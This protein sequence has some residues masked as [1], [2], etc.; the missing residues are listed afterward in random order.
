MTATY[1]FT[2]INKLRI[3]L[4]HPFTSKNWGKAKRFQRKCV[5]LW[6]RL[7]ASTKLKY[8]LR[9]PFAQQKQLFTRIFS[10]SGA[11]PATRKKKRMK[12]RNYLTISHFWGVI[13]YLR[14]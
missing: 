3:H 13:P 7:T 12:K 6:G 1:I 14:D 2:F 11:E 10:G 4:S 8:A 5:T 9:Q